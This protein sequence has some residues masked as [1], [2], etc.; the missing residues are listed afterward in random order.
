MTDDFQAA[1]TRF[2][3]AYDGLFTL[4]SNYPA[5]LVEKPGACGWWSPRQVLAHLAGWVKE[6][7]R[8]F[9]AFEAGDSASI[10]YRDRL[11]DFNAQSVAARATFTW[12]ETL[13]E[14]RAGVERL[15]SRATRLTTWQIHDPRYTEW[16]VSLQE[17]CV[18][19]TEQLRAF[20]L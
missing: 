11:D 5:A 15:A 7:N 16:L 2:R 20:L 12:G 13:D 18:E 17:D 6:A 9:D 4:V 8:R 14:L 10:A 1:V 3:A 19:H